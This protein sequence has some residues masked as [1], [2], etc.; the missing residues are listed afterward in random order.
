M[1]RKKAKAMGDDPLASIVDGK[2]SRAGGGAQA[3]PREAKASNPRPPADEALV[4]RLS[5]VLRIA[6]VAELYA[7]L[8]PSVQ[9]KGQVAIDAS[10][11]ETLDTAVFQLLCA[12]AA[13]HRSR[14]AKLAW[15]EPSQAFRTGAGLLGLESH[16]GLSP[17]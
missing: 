5:P 16:L 15:R 12:L 9:A 6:D 1:A 17:H 3:A 11:V 8:A 10:E 14:D 7:Q 2:P 13:E 4:V